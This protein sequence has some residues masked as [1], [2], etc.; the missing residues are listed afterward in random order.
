MS[1]PE[2]IHKLERLLRLID[3][4]PITEIEW[5]LA[6]VVGGKLGELKIDYWL[7]GDMMIGNLLYSLERI[8]W[9]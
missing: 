9:E 7:T 4:M 1:E 6:P 8:E 2:I 5:L 3:V